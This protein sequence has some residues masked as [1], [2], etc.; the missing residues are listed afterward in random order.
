MLY[1]TNLVL[2]VI[3]GELYLGE[4]RSKAQCIM[5][6]K[7]TAHQKSD[8]LLDLNKNQQENTPL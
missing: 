6:P 1:K 8:Y 4:T 2:A 5:Q 3:Q 7:R